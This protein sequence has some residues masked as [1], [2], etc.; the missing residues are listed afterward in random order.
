MDI[1][2]I[3]TE[4]DYQE[5]LAEIHRLWEFH[6][7]SPET[8]KLD[9]LS[10]LVVDYQNRIEPIEPPSLID[11]I[12]F[13]MD[14]MGLNRVQLAKIIVGKNAKA[15]SARGRLS[16]VL[17]GK[18]KLTLSMIQRVHAHLGVSY[19]VLVEGTVKKRKTGRKRSVKTAELRP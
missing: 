17:R 19:D 15:S 10:T 8:D 6:A 9:V 12:L 3:R 14:Q 16:E 2:P 13:R 7:G 11:A 4:A 1:R 18:R 5:A